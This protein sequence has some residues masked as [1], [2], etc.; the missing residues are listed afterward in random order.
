MFTVVFRMIWLWIFRTKFI[1]DFFFC[2]IGSTISLFE[3]IYVYVPFN[4][5]YDIYSF[6]KNTSLVCELSSHMY[7]IVFSSQYL[8]C[9][10][11]PSFCLSVIIHFQIIISTI[12]AHIQLKFNTWTCLINIQ[13]KFEFGS[14]RWFLTVLSL[15]LIKKGKF[16]FRT[17]S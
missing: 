15:E 12:V 1:I 4:G 17:L 10:P 13:V 3:H 11:V 2:F 6:E 5:M 8:L 16:T 14:V 9:Y 7:S